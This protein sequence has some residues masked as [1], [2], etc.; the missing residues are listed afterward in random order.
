MLRNS[1][2][3]LS[4]LALFIA[5]GPS[6]PSAED[7]NKMI[8]TGGTGTTGGNNTTGVIG[9]SSGSSGSAP[10]GGM[11]GSGNVPMGGMAG[12]ST[13]T[14][15]SGGM[16]PTAGSGGSGGEAQTGPYAPRSGSFKMLVLT[17]TAAYRHDD[18]IN[19]GKTMLEQI[20]QEQG[21][22]VE[23]KGSVIVPGNDQETHRLSSEEIA[24]TITTE[25]LA[26]F[27]IIFHLNTTGDMLNDEQQQIY[28][29]W[30]KNN[31]AYSG[32]HAATD[33]EQGW[34]FYN[35]MTGQYYTDHGAQNQPGQ[36]Q[37]EAAAV[38]MKFPALVFGAG[39]ALPNPWQRNEEW[40]NFNQHQVWSVKPGFIILGRKAADAQPIVW[41]REWETY[42]A[43]YTAIGH[44]GSVFTDPVVKKHLTGGIMWA[45]RRDHLIVW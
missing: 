45:V 19:S 21:F 31:G 11:A 15:G 34:P 30:M 36:I 22:E 17:R 2:L 9:G 8:A 26:R 27:E 14:G 39:D 40:Y 32:V 10:V 5:C 42:R 13:T 38:T 25:N 1:L 43:F 44:A 28:E 35:D 37:L 20:A 41:A 12:T 7:V 29:A 23:F 18:S 4:S 24:A 16:P 6:G 33:T 3:A